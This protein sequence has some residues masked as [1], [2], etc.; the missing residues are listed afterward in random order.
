MKIKTSTFLVVG[1]GKSGIASAVYLAKEGAQVYLTDM[2]QAQEMVTVDKEIEKHANIK[3]I[4]GQNPKI[5]D[6]MPDTIIV[7]PGVPLT[8]PL[9]QEGFKRNI[10]VISEL[11]LAY[12]VANS[13]FIA[14]TGTNG[15]TTT[16]ALIGQLFQDNDRNV[17]VGGNIGIPLIE[18][19]SKF[20]NNDLIVAEVSSFQLETIK[21]FKPRFAV[22]L[23]ITPDHLDRHLTLEK[24]KEAKANIFKNQEVEDFLVLNYDDPLVKNLAF[25]AKSQVIFFSRKNILE[26]G[27][28]LSQG[29]IVINIGEGPVPIC[30]P[31]EIFIKGAHN[32]E[33]AMA[34]IAV[35]YMMGLKPEEIKKTLITFKGV[36]HRLEFVTEIDGIKFIN[37][38]KG[39]NPDASIKALESY[40][41]PIVL[42]AGGKNKGNDFGEFA[43]EI[44]KHVKHLV[45]VG[46]AAP[47]IEA[48]VEDKGFKNYYRVTTFA[49][50]VH[51]AYE[52]AEKGD[53]VLLSPGC[54]SWDMFDSFEQ[55]GDYFK[56]LVCGLKN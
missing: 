24:Y 4:W 41:A 12:R 10:E 38:S 7:S 34:A 9:I 37:D 42:I 43:D 44:K 2:K 47:E 1:A 22:I 13:P 27:V 16:T 52:L 45:L 26:E 36:A 19:V 33:N 51:K 35:G 54:A 23:N 55:R 56:E 49:E 8:T 5:E 53:V 30:D 32:L 25:D 48:A 40:T 29:Q 50:A 20:N 15:K 31:Q 3:T 28:Y 46:Q 18:E 39:T 17:L 21:N 6:I 14:V 11:E